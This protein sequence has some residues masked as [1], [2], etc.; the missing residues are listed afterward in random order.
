M[1]LDTIFVSQFPA[2]AFLPMIVVTS[3]LCPETPAKT[4]SPMLA[5]IYRYYKKVYGMKMESKGLGC[6][7]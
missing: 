5:L 1:I 2:F 6:K 4:Q 7:S 3:S